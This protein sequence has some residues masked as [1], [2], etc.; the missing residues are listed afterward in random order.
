MRHLPSIPTAADNLLSNEAA[1]DLTFSLIKKF[2]C[3]LSVSSENV[4]IVDAKILF[5]VTPPPAVATA[6]T[7]TTPYDAV[8]PFIGTG[9]EARTF[10]GG[11]APFGMVPRSSDA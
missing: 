2:V 9:G 7:T 10:P 1:A 6:R 8:D 3:Q 5:F 11:S 4:W